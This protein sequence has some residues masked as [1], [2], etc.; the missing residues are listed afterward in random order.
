[1]FPSGNLVADFLSE[2]RREEVLA[3][4]R[5]LGC[6]SEGE[7]RELYEAEVEQYR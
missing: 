2:Q 3:A 6:Y 4:Y 7:W 5:R 1:M